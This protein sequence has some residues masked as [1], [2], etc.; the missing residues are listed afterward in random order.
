MHFTRST[1]PSQRARSGQ[2]GKQ[3]DS[4]SGLDYLGARYDSSS[5]GRFITADWSSVPVAVPYATLTNPQSLNLYTYVGNNPVTDVDADGHVT[6]EEPAAGSGSCGD[7][8]TC[9]QKAEQIVEGTLPQQN[10][11]QQKAPTITYDKGVPHMTP[12]TEKYLKG[13]LTDA[14]IDSVNISATTNGKHAPNSWHHDGEAVD[15]NR[16]NGVR[17]SEYSSDPSVKKGVDAIQSAAN[18]RKNGVAHENYGPAGL[19]KDGLPIRNQA[20]QREHENHIHLT[21]P[22][23]IRRKDGQ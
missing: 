9:A 6:E 22:N 17:V 19:S 3:R 18:D 10:G 16:V 14:G 20:L 15:I 11:Q 13:V 2:A 23:P 1:R 8:A 7:S 4:E 21:I 5:L 12:E